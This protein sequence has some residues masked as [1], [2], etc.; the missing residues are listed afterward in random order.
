MLCGVGGYITI[1]AQLLFLF[2]FY[3]F[4]FYSFRLTT[5]LIPI[6]FN[7]VIFLRDEFTSYN[8]LSALLIRLF[9]GN[10]WYYILV[11]LCSAKKLKAAKP[12]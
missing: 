1:G 6:D 9:D 2:S 7:Q 10:T 4:I 12:L 8:K 5:F 3:S 11:W